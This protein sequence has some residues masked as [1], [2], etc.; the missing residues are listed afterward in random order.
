MFGHAHEGDFDPSAIA[1]VPPSPGAYRLWSRGR[2]LFVGVAFGARSLRT[3]LN[4]HLRGDFGPITQA[5]SHFDC[6]VA[7]TAAHAHE[8]YRSLYA[9]SGLR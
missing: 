5:A 4:R 6:L 9:A 3:E 7:H 8:L 1:A 2:V